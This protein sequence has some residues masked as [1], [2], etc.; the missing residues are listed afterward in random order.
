[1]AFLILDMSAHQTPQGSGNPNANFNEAELNSIQDQAWQ[2]HL[3]YVLIKKEC[4]ELGLVVTDDEVLDII[5]SGQSQYLQLPIFMNQQTGTYDYS[6]V[7]N[8]LKLYKDAK[9]S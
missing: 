2:S 8:F 9:D 5:K 3:Q 4:D 7:L 1:M 6:T